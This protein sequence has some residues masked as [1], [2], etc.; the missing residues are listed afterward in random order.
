M[1]SRGLGK[2]GSKEREE[3]ESIYKR[4]EER[5]GKKG[6]REGERR[7]DRGREGER[8]LDFPWAFM[9]SMHLKQPLLLR[10]LTSSPSAA[11]NII[12]KSEVM[13]ELEISNVTGLTRNIASSVG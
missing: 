10:N 2:S 4:R 8:D 6:R 7:R 9:I 13:V 11:A 1:G 3:S 12:E 5:V